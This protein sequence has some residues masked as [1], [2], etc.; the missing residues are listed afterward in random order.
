MLDPATGTIT[1]VPLSRSDLFCAGQGVLPD[2]RLLINGG[3]S[4]SGGYGIVD[5]NVFDPSTQK[6]STAPDMKY[7]R[8]YPTMT[9]LADGTQLAYRPQNP[10]R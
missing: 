5:N 3:Q 10:C 4:H 7:N 9:P 8:W 1:T 6:W 2:G